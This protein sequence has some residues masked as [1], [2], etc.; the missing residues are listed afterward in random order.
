VTSSGDDDAPWR[1]ALLRVGTVGK[2]HGL[3][4]SA[5]VDG[6]CGWY[7]FPSGGVVLV[8]G[9]ERRVRRRA[10]TD[11]RPLLA[12]DEVVDRAGAEALRGLAIELP[13]SAAPRP[14]PDSYFHF[15]LVGCDA[16]QDGRVLGRVAAV[17]EGVVHDVLVLDDDGRTRLPFVAAVVTQVDIPGRRLVIDPALLLG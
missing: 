17:E 1:P 16:V 10:G 15:D 7:A 8:G 5:Y 13:R 14:E 6:P 9:T 3:D 12:F 11:L 4:G 2:P